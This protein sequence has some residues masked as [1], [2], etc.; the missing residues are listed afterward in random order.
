MAGE[1]KI[2]M[3]VF[4][5]AQRPAL[6]PF[7]N[8]FLVV[9]FPVAH[10]DAHLPDLGL[11]ATFTSGA[12]AFRF[13]VRWMFH[14]NAEPSAGWAHR[15]PVSPRAFGVRNDSFS[16]DIFSRSWLAK[17]NR[18][19][20][21][22]QIHEDTRTLQE[23]YPDPVKRHQVH[24]NFAHRFLPQY[25]QQ[26][27]YAFFG[28]LFCRDVPGCPMDPTRFIH[29]RWGMFEGIAGL[30][31][32]QIVPPEGGRIFRRVSDLT[33]TV[34]E[35]AGHPIALVKMPEP[36]RP[37]DAFFVAVAL[38]APAANSENWPRDVQARVFTLEVG[39]PAQVPVAKGVFCEWA[40]DGQHRNFGLVIPV[41]RGAFCETVA[42]AL[43]LPHAQVAAGFR[44]P[45]PGESGGSIQAYL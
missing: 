34:Q 16:V 40:K 31:P 7:I 1:A 24:Y 45:K 36:E 4:E 28:Y 21:N 15:A 33:M 37:P 20:M 38:L 27:P 8:R 29:S 18:Q 10:R 13:G 6:R 3:Q 11:V 12:D 19:A 30:F 17:P 9:N 14:A 43:R 39:D 42:A 32:R 22:A 5:Q 44:P 25:V 23:F 26:N 2:Q 35:L 41:E